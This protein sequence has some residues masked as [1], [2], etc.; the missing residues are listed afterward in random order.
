[1]QGKYLNVADTLSRAHTDDAPED[2]DSKEVQ[3]AVHTIIDN[4]PISETRLADI[5]AATVQDTQLQ[6]LK[7]L[8]DRGWP[9]NLCNVPD[10]LRHFWNI[11][12]NLC[13]ADDSSRQNMILKA[14]HEGHLG[15]E[16]YKARARMC[17][18]WPNIDEAIE[19]MVRECLVC[20]QYA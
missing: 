8:L 15:I 16:K 1:M 3:L 9:A 14:I 19:K 4:L 10:A 17:V 13:M 20:N 2:I 6:Q 7:Q 18:Y 11:I 12:E 5:R